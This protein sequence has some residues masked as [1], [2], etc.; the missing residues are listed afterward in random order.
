MTKGINERVGKV[1]KDG[2][3]TAKINFLKCI[4]DICVSI[5]LTKKKKTD[6]LDK[7]LELD[8]M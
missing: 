3:E 5:N 8:K 1:M 7:F 4:K 2:M 6:E